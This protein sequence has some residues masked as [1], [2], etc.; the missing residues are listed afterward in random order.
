MLLSLS[1]LYFSSQD[2]DQG[3]EQMSGS[4]IN[5]RGIVNYFHA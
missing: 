2:L 4:F 1:F 3:N 5:P